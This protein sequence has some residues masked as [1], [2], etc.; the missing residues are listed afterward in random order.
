MERVSCLMVTNRRL[1][2]FK[3]SFSSYCRQDYAN[4]QLVVVTSGSD[5]YVEELRRH[6]GDRPDVRCVP[7]RGRFSLGSLRQISVEEAAGPLI[8]Q[9]DDDDYN[10]PQRLSVQVGAMT[11]ANARAS[12]LVDNLHYFS[13]RRELY[14]CDWSP[15]RF[16]CG[17]PGTLLT[18][19]RDVPRYNELLERDEDSEVQRTLRSRVRIALLHGVGYLFLYTFHG[20]NVFGRKHHASI[21]HDYGLTASAIHNKRAALDRALAEYSPY[22]KPPITITDRLGIKVY[23]WTAE[24][25][26]W[27]LGEINHMEFSTRV[28]ES[29]P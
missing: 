18:Y 8:C 27:D 13:E 14:W 20:R 19:K 4:K 12:Y 17:H 7:L 2:W 6:I 11:G 9:W 22:L 28:L 10:H 26:S 29:P 1:N 23:L 15:S 25:T 21:A 3:Q 5:E 16:H 24:R